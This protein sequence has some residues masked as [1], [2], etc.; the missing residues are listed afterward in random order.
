MCMLSNFTFANGWAGQSVSSS[1]I[2][3]VIGFALARGIGQYQIKHF[4]GHL[5]QNALASHSQP[6]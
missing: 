3:A 5:F 4:C 1:K 6:V 2:M